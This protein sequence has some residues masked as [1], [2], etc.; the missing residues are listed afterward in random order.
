M[1]VAELVGHKGRMFLFLASFRDLF[2]SEKRKN[3]AKTQKYNKLKTGMRQGDSLSFFVIQSRNGPNNRRSRVE[4]QVI[5]WTRKKL[6]Y[7]VTPA[8]L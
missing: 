5:R 1:H 2:F 8:M 4:S 7:F 3:T 6:K